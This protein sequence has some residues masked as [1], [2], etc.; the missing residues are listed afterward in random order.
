MWH[1]TKHYQKRRPVTGFKYIRLLHDNTPAHASAIVTNFFLQKNNNKKKQKKNNKTTEGNTLVIHQDFFLFQKFKTF[2]TER[3][4]VPLDGYRSRQALGSAIYQY[5]PVY[6]DQ[7]IMT[8]SESGLKCV[9]SLGDY[10]EARNKLVILAFWMFRVKISTISLP[11]DRTRA[12]W[13]T[14]QN[15]ITSQ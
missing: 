13:V 14:E 2:L 5:L 4:S 7:R 8:Q 9:S 11:G 12:S 15:T 1:W 6:L 3:I 10:F